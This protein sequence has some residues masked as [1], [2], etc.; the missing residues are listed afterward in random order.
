MSV[1]I[2]QRGPVL[3]HGDHILQRLSALLGVPLV[4]IE[5]YTAVIR[6]LLEAPG[7]GRVAD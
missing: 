4:S 5:T 3:A 2:L 7:E 1:V 6:Q